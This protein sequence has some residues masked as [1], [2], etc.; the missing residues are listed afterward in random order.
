MFSTFGKEISVETAEIADI[1]TLQ[2]PAR[3]SRVF[4]MFLIVA[5]NHTILESANHVYIPRAQ[6]LE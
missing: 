3:I 5:L 4:Q 6:S 1:V 2:D